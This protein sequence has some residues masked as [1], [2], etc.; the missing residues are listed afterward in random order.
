MIEAQQLPE[1][2]VAAGDKIVVGNEDVDSVGWLLLLGHKGEAGPDP[3]VGFDALGIHGGLEAV[4]VLVGLLLEALGGGVR[5]CLVVH[6]PEL[7]VDLD[8]GVG[9]ALALLAGVLVCPEVRRLVPAVEEAG[10]QRVCPDRLGHLDR[11]GEVVRGDHGAAINGRLEDLPLL[12]AQL[13][14]SVAV[15][16]DGEVLVEAVALQDELVDHL[17]EDQRRGRLCRVFAV[18][19]ELFRT[20]PQPPELGPADCRVC[21]VFVFCHFGYVLP[22]FHSAKSFAHTESSRM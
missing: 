4:T 22:S 18:V 14:P 6:D 7:A 5:G 11:F 16:S 10:R 3:G 8:L 13:C 15:R 1:G 9:P 21:S 20:F 17:A 12:A 19:H 2:V